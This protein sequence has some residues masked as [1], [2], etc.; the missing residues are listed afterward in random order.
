MKVLKLVAVG[1][2]AVGKTSLLISYAQ[3]V[4]PGEYVPT[5]FDNYTTTVKFQGANVKLDLWDTAGENLL[6][7]Y[8]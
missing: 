2:G 8:M 1:D 3:G 4:F 7:V 5:I 6:H